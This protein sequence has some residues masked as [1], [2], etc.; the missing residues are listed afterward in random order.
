MPTVDYHFLYIDPALNADW[1][2]TAA[3]RY[4]ERFRPIVVTSYDLITYLP[5]GRS[6]AI[7]TLAR[8]D[9]AKKLADDVRKNFPRAYH[10]PLVYDF[11][12][13]MQLTLD[14]RAAL[15]QRF[16]IPENATPT[17]RRKGR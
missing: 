6:F 14:G 12:E 17:P 15:Q 7:T 2:F 11:V 9:F 1:L 5:A 16:G 3:R 4:W 10:D 13:E 8:R